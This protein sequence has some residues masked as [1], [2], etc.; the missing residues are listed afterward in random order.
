MGAPITSVQWHGDF[1]HKASPLSFKWSIRGTGAH[2]WL[3]ITL[4]LGAAGPSLGEALDTRQTPQGSQRPPLPPHPHK[5]PPGTRLSQYCVS[6]AQQGLL[7]P[8]YLPPC[9]AGLVTPCCDLF[10]ICTPARWGFLGPESQLA[11]VHTFILVMLAIHGANVHP[12]CSW[13]GTGLTW[14]AVETPVALSPGGAYVSAQ[15]GLECSS[16]WWVPGAGGSQ[17][18]ALRHI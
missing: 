1:L 4:G 6:Q 13:A 10:H 2:E 9:H 16:P 11:H 17:E 7:P 15:P 8:L 14:D 18:P 3:Q 5:E 12:V